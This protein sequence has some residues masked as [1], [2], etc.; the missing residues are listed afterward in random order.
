MTGNRV[1]ITKYT[2]EPGQ[3]RVSTYLSS[4]SSSDS[5]SVSSLESDI[6]AALLT[7]WW[8]PVVDLPWLRWAEGLFRVLGIAS[9]T[10]TDLECTVD[11]FRR[12]SVDIKRA[13]LKIIY[14]DV[15]QAS[16][17]PPSF[18]LHI[19]GIYFIF[20]LFITADGQN[21]ALALPF[22]FPLQGRKLPGCIKLV[23]VKSAWYI[24]YF[25]RESRV[26]TTQGSFGSTS[27]TSTQLLKKSLRSK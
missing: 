21:I 25:V 1:L 3:A 24:P 6:D 11:L 13:W 10:V 9:D 19:N 16:C 23:N 18:P 17:F 5:S 8:A 20:I 12:K 27:K 15:P 14:L 4:L 7:A 2:S 26:C 22:I